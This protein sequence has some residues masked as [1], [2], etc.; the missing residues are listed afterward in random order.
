MG[1][2]S[3][4]STPFKI[5]ASCYMLFTLPFFL[6]LDCCEGLVLFFLHQVSEVLKYFNQLK[7]S[8]S[9]LI[10]NVNKSMIPEPE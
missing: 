6:P 7:L 10:G 2:S 5:E 1:Q 4:N 3:F 8:R 9:F